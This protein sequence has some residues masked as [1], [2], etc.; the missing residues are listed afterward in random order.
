[1]LLEILQQWYEIEFAMHLFYI[2]RFQVIAPYMLVS[3]VNL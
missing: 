2:T 1:M 3:A